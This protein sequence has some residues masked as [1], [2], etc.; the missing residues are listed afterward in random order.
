MYTQPVE[1]YKCVPL[2]LAVSGDGQIEAVLSNPVIPAPL[3]GEISQWL[4][5]GLQWSDIISTLQPCTVPPGYVCNSW[6][7]GKWIKPLY[8]NVNYVSCL[9]KRT[10]MEM[11]QSVL[12]Q[13]EFT[14]IV[15]K[16][17]AAHVPF[18]THL[19][20]PEIH[21]TTGSISWKWFFTL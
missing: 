20:V 2:C 21:P 18:R 15:Q 6:K 10:E 5:Q 9:G 8:F 17:D 4:S 11:Y 13:L 7:P 12:A 14:Y 16:Y 19:H 3:L 1:P